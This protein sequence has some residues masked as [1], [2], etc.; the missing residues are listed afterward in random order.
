MDTENALLRWLFQTFPH[1]CPVWK[2]WA[3]CGLINELQERES[4]RRADGNDKLFAETILRLRFLA[5]SCRY[6]GRQA[7]P[8]V[9]RIHHIHP[10]KMAIF[11]NEKVFS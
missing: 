7:C 11:F 2:D 8:G 6:R 5:R 4:A 3:T 1:D 9:A 10:V